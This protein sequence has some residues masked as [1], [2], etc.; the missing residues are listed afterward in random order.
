MAT[1]KVQAVV[2]VYIPCC[3]TAALL[4]RVH[5]PRRERKLRI[6]KACSPL[7][8]WLRVNLITDYVGDL[9]QRLAHLLE[10]P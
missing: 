8:A 2:E 5:S 4:T 6:S 3:F 10:P 1:K 7:W 9:D